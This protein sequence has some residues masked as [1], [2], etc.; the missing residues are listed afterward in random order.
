[1]GYARDRINENCAGSKYAEIVPKIFI[2]HQR[3]KNKNDDVDFHT[4]DRAQSLIVI[5]ITPIHRLLNR[6]VKAS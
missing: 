6:C 3:P 2:F 1:M 4:G 5:D